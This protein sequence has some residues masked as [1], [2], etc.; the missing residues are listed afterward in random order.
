ML[1]C[2]THTNVDREF[3]PG[4]SY[5]RRSLTGY[6]PRGRKEPPSFSSWADS[7]GPTEA[8]LFPLTASTPLPP[9]FVKASTGLLVT[10]RYPSLS[11]TVAAIYRNYD[12]GL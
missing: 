4:E 7:E 2:V 1:L 11:L 6:S 12:H 8:T 9:F 5:G 3:L 10:K